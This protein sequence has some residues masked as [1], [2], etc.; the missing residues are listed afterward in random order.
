MIPFLDL[1]Q[2]NLPLQSELEEAILRVAK[3]GWFVLGKEVTEFEH[4]FAAFCEAG[5]CIGVANGL[6]AISLILKSYDFPEG[7]EVIVPSNTYIA[8]VLPVDALGLVPVLAE[9]DPETMLLTAGSIAGHL[10]PKTKAIITVDLYGK[11]CDLDPILEIA[12]SHRLR[13][14]TDAAQAHGASYKGKKVGGLADATAF[15]FYPTKNLGAWGD[16]GAVTT[17]DPELA[18]KI[19][20]LRNYGSEKRYQNEYQ[21]VN[22]RLDEIQAA[23]LNVKLRNLEAD[24]M[25]RRRIA[26][27]YLEEIK[28]AGLRLPPRET[29]TEDAWHL[30]VCRHAERD[31]LRAWLSEHGI[32]TDV[33]Y[34]QPI[35]RQKAYQHLNHANLPVATDISRQAISL[36]LHPLLSDQDLSHIIETLNRFV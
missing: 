19:R 20:M 10:S 6:D 26:A 15:S 22:S 31:R 9:P 12:Q 33:H 30:F 7:S 1:R 16:A 23:V 25:A 2:I 11:S 18:G 35:H 3:S 32:Q 8:S 36:P 34:P 13:V 5:H 17:N 27:K 29:V 24:N 21:G 28:V 4:S 14:I